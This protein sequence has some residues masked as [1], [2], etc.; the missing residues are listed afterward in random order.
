MHA[1]INI[2]EKAT[3]STGPMEK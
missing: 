2:H 3:L 1:H